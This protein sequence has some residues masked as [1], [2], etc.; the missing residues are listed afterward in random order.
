M[1]AASGA[2]GSMSL[3]RR[4]A[5]ADA[6]NWE[7]SQ[8]LLA[9]PITGT[10]STPRPTSP[11]RAGK[12][13]SLARSPV[14]PKMTRASARS[15]TPSSFGLPGPCAQP[16]A[17]VVAGP[18]RV[19]DGGQ[20]GVHGADA[21]EEAGVHHVEVVQLVGLAHRV[22]RGG[23]GIRAEPDRAGLVRGGTDRHRLVQVDAVVEQVLLE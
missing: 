11:T 5:S 17:D 20:R 15:L 1:R 4:D 19:G 23:R 3:S 6:L 14:A 10:S 12:V 9:T 21:G 2:P 8:P 22:E 18:Q 16:L 13:S 7:R